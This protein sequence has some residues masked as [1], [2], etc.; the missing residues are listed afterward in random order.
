MPPSFIDVGLES[1]RQA[2]CCTR[3]NRLEFLWWI[4]AFDPP[5]CI[6]ERLRLLRFR[7]P[8][9]FIT[10]NTGQLDQLYSHQSHPICRAT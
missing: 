8:L 9:S 7:P 6:V 3:P 1:S 10:R 5:N 2:Y 4:S